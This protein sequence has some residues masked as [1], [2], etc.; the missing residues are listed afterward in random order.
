MWGR[1]TDSVFARLKSISKTQKQ[2]KLPGFYNEVEFDLSRS[3]NA[4]HN[5]EEDRLLE[6]THVFFSFPIFV[7]F[8]WT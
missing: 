8:N 7:R 6:D 4:Q 5:R 1:S 2:Y 3:I